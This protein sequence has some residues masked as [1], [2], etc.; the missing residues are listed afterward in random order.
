MQSQLS[1][2]KLLSERIVTMI[3]IELSLC[4]FHYGINGYHVN[5]L[6]EVNVNGLI[7]V[8]LSA[9]ELK[10]KHGYRIK[11]TKLQQILICINVK[12]NKSKN[13]NRATK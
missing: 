5:K 11:K 12:L 10:Q 4:R 9:G 7:K 8:L 13:T 1:G 6:M 2:P 3:S